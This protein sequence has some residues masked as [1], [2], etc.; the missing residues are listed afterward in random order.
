MKTCVTTKAFSFQFKSSEISARDRNKAVCSE[1]K[2]NCTHL[3]RRENV[4]DHY[5]DM[6]KRYSPFK[7]L[8]RTQTFSFRSKAFENSDVI[9]RKRNLN[10]P[11]ESVEKLFSFNFPL[12]I[13]I[14]FF[15]V[16]QKV[17]DLTRER[18]SPRSAYNC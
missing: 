2:A 15:R 17:L 6:I 14:L 11:K 16:S 8:I 9:A 18:P 13:M 12:L 10:M 3:N 1:S 5:L 7:T 4:V